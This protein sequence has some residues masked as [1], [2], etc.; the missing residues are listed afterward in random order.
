MKSNGSVSFVSFV[1][2]LVPSRLGTPTIG[3]ERLDD[4]RIR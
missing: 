4:P 1:M 3:A 2:K